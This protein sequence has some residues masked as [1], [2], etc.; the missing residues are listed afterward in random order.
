[1]DMD[2]KIHTTLYPDRSPPLEF[3]NNHD[4]DTNTQVIPETDAKLSVMYHAG[5]E[6]GYGL[7]FEAG[8]QVSDYF[9]AIQ[10]STLG[11]SFDTVTFSDTTT[12]RTNFFMQGPYARIQ[13]DVA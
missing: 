5:L 2:T 3:N 12:Q 11:T 6:N 7:N 4:V 13:L 8:Y 9:N 1:M 10:N